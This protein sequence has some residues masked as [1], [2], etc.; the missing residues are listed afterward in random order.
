M[1]QCFRR[2]CKFCRYGDRLLYGISCRLYPS[3]DLPH[4]AGV[5]GRFLDEISNIVNQ[6]LLLVEQRVS[7]SSLHETVQFMKS[8]GTPNLHIPDIFPVLPSLRSS[9]HF[10]EANPS[11]TDLVL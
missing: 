10:V 3:S 11:V 9:C 2:R 7:E 4:H 8:T 6:A 5:G 1:A